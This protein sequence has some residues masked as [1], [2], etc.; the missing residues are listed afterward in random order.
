MVKTTLVEL[1]QTTRTC[2]I[3][4]TSNSID[5]TQPIYTR[6]SSNTESIH[7]QDGVELEVIGMGMAH[8]TL[9]H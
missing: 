4:I 1:L 9:H 3:A 2:K 7:T 8:S 5:S 6:Y